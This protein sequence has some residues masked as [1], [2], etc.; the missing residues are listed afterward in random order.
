MKMKN[1]EQ[2]FATI[3]NLNMHYINIWTFDIDV[4]KYINIRDMLYS[5]ER[6]YIVLLDMSLLITPIMLINLSHFDVAET[7]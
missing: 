3:V 5:V 7:R 4:T 2:S 1:H 6:L